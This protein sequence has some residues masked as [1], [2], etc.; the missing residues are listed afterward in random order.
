MAEQSLKD[1]LSSAQ[2]AF[3]G[4]VAAA[5]RSGVAGMAGDERT[6]IVA[7][8]RAIKAPPGLRLPPGSRVTVQL[9]RT[10]PKLAV[11]EAATF[12]ADG[13]VYGDTLGV[14]EVGRAPAAETVAPAVGQAALAG[15]AELPLSPV[16]EAAAELAVDEVVEHARKADAV[17]RG[18]VIGLSHLPKEEPPKEHDADWW[19]AELEV[20]VLVRGE[21]PAGTQPGGSVS[22]LYANSLDVM[23][24]QSPKPKAGQ[25]GL[26]LLHHAR[27]EL[28]G[29][30]PFELVHAI[31]LQPS[32]QLDVLR[33]RGLATEAPAEQAEQEEEEAGGAI[34]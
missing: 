34:A 1:L 31:D 33:E 13:L 15:G 5:G 21:L 11:G 24:R 7:V 27:R 23:W 10:L 12:F 19:I 4:A 8:D 30:A 25:S 3:S 16:E 9:S 14:S 28:A 2:L 26:W 20:D 18:H 17:I 32:L 22:V 29:V 6:V